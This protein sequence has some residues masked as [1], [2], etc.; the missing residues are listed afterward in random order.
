MRS[1]PHLPHPR[2]LTLMCAMAFAGTAGAAD[3]P[4]ATITISASAT[5]PD[6]EP[7]SILNPYRLES[8]A[9]FGSEVMS[10]KDIEA[11]APRD[12]I[13]LLDKAVG[14]NVTYQGRRSPYFVEERG[15]AI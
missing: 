3:S 4:L 2:P 14:M 11:L 12:V 7:E 10:R 1:F 13:D 9:Q 5:R 8:T 15:G 6:L